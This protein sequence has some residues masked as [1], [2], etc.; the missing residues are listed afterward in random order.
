MEIKRLGAEHYDELLEMLNY[1]FGSSYKRPMDFLSEQPKM[2]V[3]DDEHMGRHIGIFEDGKL[4]SVVGIYP[5]KTFIEGEEFLFAT[6]G[7]VATLP[8]YEGRGYFNL[9]FSE[10]MKELDRIGADAARL[11]GLRQRYGRFGYEMGG[12]VYKFT[13]LD[14]NRIRGFGETAGEGIEFA[15]IKADDKAALAFCCELSQKRKIHVERTVENAYPSTCSRHNTPY[16]AYRDGKMIG[17][18]SASHKKDT[19]EEINALTC[20]DMIDM[21]CAWQKQNRV[22]VHFELPCY[23]TE[24]VRAFWASSNGVSIAAATQFK[25]INWQKLLNTLMRAKAKSEKLIDGDFVVEIEGYGKLRLFVCG[26]NAGCEPT[27][28]QAELTID[29]RMA[30]RLLLGPA[31]PAVVADIPPIPRSWLPLHMSWNTLDSI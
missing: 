6:T 4:C 9:I 10:I 8:E 7:N 16:A 30:T 22:C 15:E 17:Y 27:D 11:G 26:E 2:W 18:L 25:I 29:G 5:L 31:M 23:M 24:E 28:K 21:V 13:F 1:T 19:V 20:R 14:H 3:R 12:T